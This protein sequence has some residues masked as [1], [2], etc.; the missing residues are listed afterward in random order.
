[1]IAGTFALCMVLLY[2][3]LRSPSIKKSGNHTHKV[4]IKSNGVAIDEQVEL[5]GKLMAG[6][7]DSLSDSLW[8]VLTIVSESDRKLLNIN[9][10]HEKGCDYIIVEYQ[11]D[12]KNRKTVYI[13]VAS[14]VASDS[15]SII[16]DMQLA[17]EQSEVIDNTSANK[18]YK[19]TAIAKWAIGAVTA[20]SVVVAVYEFGWPV[21]QGH[22]A[23]KLFDKATLVFDRGAYDS[24]FQMYKQ[25][26]TYHEDFPEVYINL[27]HIMIARNKP[28]SALLMFNKAEESRPD[29]DLALYG[30]GYAYFLLEKYN[31]SVTA[32]TAY[33]QLGSGDADSFAFLGD[34]YSLTGRPD[35]AQRYYLKAYDAGY[36]S[37]YLSYKIGEFQHEANE[38]QL[39]IDSYFE[40]LQQDSTFV[41][42]WASLAAVMEA[43]GRT[44]EA[45]A[46]LL[47]SEF[48]SQE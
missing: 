11:Q 35:S 32:F 45:E 42:A 46:F 20:L 1:M 26:L 25:T 43:Q 36:R 27:G 7:H 40:C 6:A 22:L 23:D 15:Q 39:A 4:I 33:H 28:D 37:A 16:D 18:K 19:T 44:E 34:A 10:S 47:K 2:F 30:Q 48:Y 5:W 3:N 31:E 13:P 38:I 14:T 17:Y 41:D 12:S 9:S 24:A 8:S 29:Y 21:Y